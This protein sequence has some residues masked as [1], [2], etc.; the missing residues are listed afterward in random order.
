MASLCMYPLQKHRVRLIIID[1]EPSRPDPVSLLSEITQKY[2]TI[3]D[4]DEFSLDAIYEQR[5]Q[6][7]ERAVVFD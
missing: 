1:L 5:E 4:E 2:A 3:T 7:Y 6:N